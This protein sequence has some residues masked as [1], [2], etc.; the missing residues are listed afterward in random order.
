VDFT[1]LLGDAR[2][3]G[4]FLERGHPLLADQLAEAVIA[5][6]AALAVANDVEGSHIQKRLLRLMRMRSLHVLTESTQEVRVIPDAHRARVC[7]GERVANV[8]TPG[9]VPEC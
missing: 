8:R 2:D 1:H 9:R 7:D 4:D 5:G 6:N 3:A